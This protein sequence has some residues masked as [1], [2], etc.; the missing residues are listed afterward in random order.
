MR[1]FLLFGLVAW[2]QS[3]FELFETRVRP[4]LVEKCQSCH[5]GKTPMAGIDLS[6]GAGARKAAASL[7]G[8]ISYAGRVK[9]PP[10]G[11]LTDAEIAALS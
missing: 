1:Y 11:K 9:M 2:G 6:T 3:K 7:A 4:V 5:G 8:A 10:S